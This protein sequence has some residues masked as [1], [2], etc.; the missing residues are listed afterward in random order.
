MKNPMGGG[1]RYTP[2]LTCKIPWRYGVSISLSHVNYVFL[3]QYKGE[4]VDRS[5]I[6][7]KRKISDI[8]TW[9]KHL[10]LDTFST[11]IDTR[12]PSLYPCVDASSTQVFR[13]FFSHFSTTVS[14]SSSSTKSFSTQL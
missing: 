10:F 3:T 5:Q 2:L 1:V 11:N 7:I 4:S 6:D 12:V 14:T 13:L 8:R 9:K